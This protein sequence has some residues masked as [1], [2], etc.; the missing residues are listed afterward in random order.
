MA[1]APA[2]TGEVRMLIDGEARRGR[3]RERRSTTSTRPPRRSSA[4]WPTRRPRRCSAPSRP[5]G[6]PSTR[7]TGRRT[8]QFRKRCLQQLQ[9]ALEAEQEELREELVAEVGSPR[10]LTHLLQLDV[11]LA[12]G[13]RYPVKMI[14]EFPWERELPP[15]ELMGMASSRRQVW[16]EPIGVIGAIVPWNYPFEVTINKLAQILATGNTMVL[17]PAPDTPVER[18]PPRPARRRE[19]RHPRRRRSTS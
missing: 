19:D 17:K 9:D 13:L 14:D 4:P 12:D 16:K 3:R 6:G 7:P 5:P 2:F 15:T 11:P 18:H 10:F 8:A 1:D